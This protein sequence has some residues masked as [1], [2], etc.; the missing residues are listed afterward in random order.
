VSG[1]LDDD[2]ERT[3]LEAATMIVADMRFAH[4]TRD[5]ARFGRDVD[6]LL[7]IA[8]EARSRGL[9]QESKGKVGRRLTIV[10]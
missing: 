8:T 7:R 9:H 2:V 10:S 4:V 5:T 3:V 1:Q 6:R